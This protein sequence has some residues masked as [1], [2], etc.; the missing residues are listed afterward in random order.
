LPAR[1]LR[2]F[3]RAS[4]FGASTE[5]RVAKE[6]PV[7]EAKDQSKQSRHTARFSRASREIPRDQRG[8][9]LA[10]H[11]PMTRLNARQL[12]ALNPVRLFYE[13][14]IAPNRS[15]TCAKRTT[16]SRTS[17]STKHRPP[18]SLFGNEIIDA[19]T[20]ERLPLEQFTSV[21]RVSF[22]QCKYQS[23]PTEH[24]TPRGLQSLS[25]LDQRS[26]RQTDSLRCLDSVL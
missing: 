3:S 10:S 11:A 2:T 15:S 9:S 17:R 25:G 23:N 18:T 12:R 1:E 13:D 16:R 14:V 21:R 19:F 6:A 7:V 5:T 4:A 24:P 20:P 8:L 26:P 22:V